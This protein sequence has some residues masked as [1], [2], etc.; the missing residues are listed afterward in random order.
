MTGEFVFRD[1]LMI[2][3]GNILEFT[4]ARTKKSASWKT[5]GG[6]NPQ[7][8]NEGTGIIGDKVLANSGFHTRKNSSENYS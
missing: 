7:G 3:S 8:A 6:I 2:I 5:S 4:L 1:T